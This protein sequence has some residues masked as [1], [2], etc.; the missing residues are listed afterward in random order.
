MN[1]PLNDQEVQDM[2]QALYKKYAQ[3][4]I[5]YASKFVDRATA[6]DLVQ[7]VFLKIWN[8]RLLIVWAEGLPSYLFNAV[9]HACIDYLKHIEI[10]NHIETNILT[11]LKMEELS[12]SGDSA[13]FWQENHRLQSIYKEIENLPQQ[14]RRIFTMSYLEERKSS[15]IASLLNISKRTVEAQLYKALKQIREALCKV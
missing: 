5:I 2:F 12:Y 9:Q 13:S 15:E 7:D 8:K 1:E 6:E 11:K 4:L 10:K 3:I 14:C